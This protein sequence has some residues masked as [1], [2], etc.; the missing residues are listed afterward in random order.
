MLDVQVSFV[1]KKPELAEAFE[2]ELY[3]KGL[4]AYYTVTA[5]AAKYNKVVGPVEGISRI[6][7]IFLAV[8]LVLGSLILILLSTMA[9]RERK[10]EVGVLRAMGMKKAKVA[11]GMVT[12]MMVII[13]ACLVIGLGIGA[14]AAQPIADSLL[15]SQVQ[16]SQSD[17]V[18][19][20]NIEVSN[21]IQT[22]ENAI[23]ELKVS[24]SGQAVG[25]IVLIALLLALL[26]SVAGVIFITRYEP[27]KILSERN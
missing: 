20:N 27:V 23:T 24:L 21:G 17:P 8:V 16:S 2:Q 25:Q 11:L 4:P 26:S 13:T 6:V 15:Q 18:Q 7:T 12:E 5:D 19:E 3:E 10:Y 14:A 9:I 22:S 1:L